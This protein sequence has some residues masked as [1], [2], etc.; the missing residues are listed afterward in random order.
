MLCKTELDRE[1]KEKSKI[2]I[3]SWIKIVD[4]SELTAAQIL[5]YF[6]KT[7]LHLHLY[8]SRNMDLKQ[9]NFFKENKLF[10]SHW[11]LNKVQKFLATKY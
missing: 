7:R 3:E 10:I 8:C 11:N 4:S 5:I 6:L 1:N 2:K 9:N